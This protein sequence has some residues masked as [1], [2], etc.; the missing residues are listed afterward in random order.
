M[1]MQRDDR[2]GGREGDLSTEDIAGPG[3]DVRTRAKDESMAPG[4]PTR[5]QGVGDVPAER[6]VSREAKPA[7]DAEPLVGSEEAEGLR[8]RWQKIQNE[9]VDDPQDAVRAADALVAE[10]MQM[11]ATTFA[12]HKQGLEGQWEQGRQVQ[13]EELRVA[14]QRYRSFFHRLLST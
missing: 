4:E 10:V 3:H 2:P 9:F 8:S 7:Q 6:D 13:T 1:D 11:L 12:A 5:D 14:L